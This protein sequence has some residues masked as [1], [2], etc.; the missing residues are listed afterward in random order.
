[1][2]IR[3]INDNGNILVTKDTP[4]G[5]STTIYRDLQSGESIVIDVEAAINTT[6]SSG[7]GG[8]IK[9]YFSGDE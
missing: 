4:D 3:I 1:M 7:I 2:K 6:V 5:T 8:N 9:Q